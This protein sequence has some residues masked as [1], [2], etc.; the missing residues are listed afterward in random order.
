MGGD[1]NICYSTTN[2]RYRQTPHRIWELSILRRAAKFKMPKPTVSRMSFTKVQ[3][4]QIYFWEGHSFHPSQKTD[5]ECAKQK[6]HLSI[7]SDHC[8]VLKR[9]Q[10]RWRDEL[11]LSFAI[12]VTVTRA[13]R[14]ETH[15]D[16]NNSNKYIINNHDISDMLTASE[17]PSYESTITFG[18]ARSAPINPIIISFIDPTKKT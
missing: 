4:Y 9:Q 6:Q 7:L 8:D 15:N 17:R 12:F 16:S 10:N 2:A 5:L 18:D 11:N 13:T 3:L 1:G 14:A